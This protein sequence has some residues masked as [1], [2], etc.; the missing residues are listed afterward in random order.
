MPEYDYTD[1]EWKRRIALL[2]GI[3]SD[4]KNF[5]AQYKNIAA[6]TTKPIRILR[7]NCEIRP[8]GDPNADRWQNLYRDVK[9]K[10]S[11][12]V[13]QVNSNPEYRLGYR[14]MLGRITTSAPVFSWS[15]SGLMRDVR[16]GYLE[17][18]ERLN[19]IGVAFLFPYTLPSSSSP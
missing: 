17:K 11:G 18:G 3:R 6:I 5:M 8:I 14:K 1:T 16:T 7:L 12:I 2:E 4:F 9:G 15:A 13:E 19:P 10:V